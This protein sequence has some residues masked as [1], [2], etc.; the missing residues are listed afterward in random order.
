MTTDLQL[1]FKFRVRKDKEM[2][3]KCETFLGGQK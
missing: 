2:Q 1:Q 3:K